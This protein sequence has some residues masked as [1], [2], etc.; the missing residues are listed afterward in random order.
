MKTLVTLNDTHF[1]ITVVK[2]TSVAVFQPGYI[3]EANGVISSV[4]DTPS[5]AINFLYHTLFSSKTR[6]SGTFTPTNT[7]WY[8]FLLNWK[9]HNCNI[10][11]LY[12]ALKNIYPEEYQF[13]ERELHA[14]KALLRSI[15]CT[16]ITPFEKDKSEKEFWSK[17]ENPA[18]DKHIFL[19]LYENNFLDMS[20]PD[21][22]SNPIVNK[23]WSC[24]NE[25][26]KQ[27]KK[28]LMEKGEFYQ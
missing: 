12:S 6:F 4:Y 5:G 25:S 13:K 22:H 18:D 2:G 28:D 27:I 17:T 8:E 14:W 1:I 15:G 19:Y 26:L 23:F 24:F 3:C 7:L 9:E 11:E 10:I 21:D 20:L 16:N